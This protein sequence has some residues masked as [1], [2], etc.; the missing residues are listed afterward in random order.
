MYHFHLYFIAL[1]AKWLIFYI[2]SLFLLQSSRT[3][4]NAQP[5][6]WSMSAPS[7]KRS[8][9]P[10][11]QLF[12]LLAF[13]DGSLARFAEG[14]DSVRQDKQIQSGIV[15]VV[16]RKVA[17]RSRSID[18]L[19]NEIRLPTNTVNSNKASEIY[20]QER[21]RPDD[22]GRKASSNTTTQSTIDFR[23]K[24]TSLRARYVPSFKRLTFN[25]RTLTKKDDFEAFDSSS[26]HIS[27]TPA[28]SSRSEV[29]TVKGILKRSA[30]IALSDTDSRLENSPHLIQRPKVQFEGDPIIKFYSMNEILDSKRQSQFK[31]CYHR[32]KNLIRDIFKLW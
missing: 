23:G 25:E 32:V 10:I 27:A 12:I 21:T 24:T 7:K 8:R 19:R 6:I 15:D 1:P 14:L 22:E 13:L 16:I 31:R 20:E 28:S 3:T 4:R 2:V 18:R 29:K 17:S 11:I 9:A 5:T 30:S 26:D